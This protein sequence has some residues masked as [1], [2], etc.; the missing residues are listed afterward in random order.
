MKTWLMA[1]GLMSIAASAQAA[2]RLQIGAKP[3][4]AT[5]EMEGVDGK[6]ITIA[7]AKGAKGTLV[8]FTCN[9]CPYVKAW[10]QRIAAIGNEWS[11]KGFG[12]VAINPNDPSEKPEDSMDG[13]KARAQK[14]G[15][16]FPYVVDSTSG[17]A[18]A[19][20]ATKTPEI[21]LFDAND[22]LVY[23]GAVDDNAEEPSKVKQPYLKNALEAVAAGKPVPMAETKALGCSI[24]FRS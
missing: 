6:K 11:K 21:F 22:K 17:I 3:P 7:K 4:M 13:M 9:H 8:I 19:F 14:L 12:V 23:Y 24:K 15:L 2:D 18:K 5:T 10:E 16:T 20:G 1:L